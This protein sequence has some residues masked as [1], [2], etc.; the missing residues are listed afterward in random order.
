M[1]RKILELFWHLG[2]LRCFLIAWCRVEGGF[3]SVKQNKDHNN[4][5]MK[6]AW[7]YELHD[8]AEDFQLG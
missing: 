3:C 8:T 1:G 6:L 2:F 5:G 4:E 7:Q